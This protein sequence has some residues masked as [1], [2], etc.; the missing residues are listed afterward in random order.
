MKKYIFTES[1]IKSLLKVMVNE[2][3]TP[4]TANEI[5]PIKKVKKTK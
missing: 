1:Q 5:K 3:N 4:K 2:S